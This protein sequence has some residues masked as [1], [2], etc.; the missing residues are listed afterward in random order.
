M[1]RSPRADRSPLNRN[2]GVGSYNIPPLIG[3]LPS[4]CTSPKK[5]T[6]SGYSTFHEKLKMRILQNKNLQK[7]S[8]IEK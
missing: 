2:P 7:A 4:Y 5:M 3:Q 1:A 8:K 6:E